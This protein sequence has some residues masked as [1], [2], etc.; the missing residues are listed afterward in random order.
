MPE[1]LPVYDFLGIN[2]LEANYSRLRPGK[3]ESFAIR[4]P[5]HNYDSFKKIYVI[6]ILVVLNFENDSKK[7]STLSFTA[8]FKINDEEWMKSIDNK[9]FNSLLLS[10][11]F[12]YV[13]K[14]VN[15]ITDDSRGEFIMPII[16][17]RSIDLEK[18][19]RY[20]ISKNK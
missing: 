19:V 1:L 18:G 6:G 13:R 9:Q 12:P 11:A 17:L 14:M 15:D 3:V 7:E 16:D 2:L 5:N 8:G 20:T 4:I 10:I